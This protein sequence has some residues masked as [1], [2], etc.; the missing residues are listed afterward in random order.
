M[1]VKG[2]D[3]VR[4]KYRETI[5]SITVKRAEATMAKVVT[6]AAGASKEL[7]PIEFGNLVNSQF[8]NVEKTATGYRGTVG[9]TVGYAA[10]LENPKPGG[11][12]DNWKPLAP[13]NKQGNAWNP[14]SG[15]GFLRLGFIGIESK[16]AIRKIIINGF[17]IK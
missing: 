16:P 7:A 4:K 11:K 1:P 10:A 8:R 5:K 9:Y 3:S 13:E 6:Y 15:Q 12:L 2:G 14:I 17:K